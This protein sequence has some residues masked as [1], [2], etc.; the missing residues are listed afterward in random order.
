MSKRID[1]EIVLRKAKGYATRDRRRVLDALA[2]ARQPVTAK[3]L[4]ALL[5]RHSCDLATVHRTLNFFLKAGI[6]RGTSFDGHSRWFDIWDKK[7]HGHHVF[8]TSCGKIERIPLCRIASFA[9][10]ASNQKGYEVTAHVLELFG[11]CP[12]CRGDGAPPKGRVA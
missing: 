11:R 12:A 5:G 8:C 10:F 4:H 7:N 2:R 3:Q 6:V 1:T 9:R